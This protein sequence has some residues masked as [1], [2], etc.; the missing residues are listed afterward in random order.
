[1]IIRATQ[2]HGMGVS[3]RADEDELPAWG[4]VCNPSTGEGCMVNGQW[5]VNPW[6]NFLSGGSAI[7][8]TISLA[9]ISGQAEMQRAQAWLEAWVA[10]FATSPRPGAPAFIRAEPAPGTGI[11]TPGNPIGSGG[12]STTGGGSGSGSGSG[13]GGGAG[14][15]GEDLRASKSSIVALAVG[16]IAVLMLMR[17]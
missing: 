5:Q 1:M 9:L 17:R 14:S 15:A 13:S 6:A 10:P 4:G 12:G 8:H 16:G 3:L 7:A 11:A 2:L